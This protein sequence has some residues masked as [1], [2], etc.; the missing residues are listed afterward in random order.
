MTR[1]EITE[2]YR[3]WRKQY[4]NHKPNRAVVTMYWEDECPN[5]THHA[6][7]SL[8]PYDIDTKDDGNIL[9]FASGLKGLCELTQTGNGSDFVVVEVNQF[10][11][12]P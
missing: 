1:K 4:G 9:F 12:E 3:A 7:V 10:Y 8:I 6:T 5:A 2:K 11:R